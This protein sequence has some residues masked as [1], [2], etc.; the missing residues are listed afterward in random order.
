MAYLYNVILFQ[1]LLN[2][3]VGL[4]D[5]I[6]GHDIGLAIIFLTLLIRLAL[7][8]LSQRGL[9]S[10]RAMQKLQPKLK[11]LQKKYKKNR[12]VLAR[13]TMRLYKEHNIHP[14]SALLPALIQLP[15]LIALYQVFW[16]GF[17]EQHIGS[18]LSSTL[19]PFVGN[20][21]TLNP[22]MFGGFNLAKASIALA[23]AAGIAQFAQGKLMFYFRGVPQANNN[24]NKGN[25]PDMGRVMQTQMT[26]ILPFFTVF[27]ALRFPAALAL[28][29]LTT[30]L[31]T[32]GQEIYLARTNP[33]TRP[34][35]ASPE[36]KPR[37]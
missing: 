4:Y 23:I 26:Y 10:Q 1:P 2:A 35:A 20:P 33:S 14:F 22:I 6:P 24:N 3:L 21:G 28:Y 15:V 8:P 12:E 29:W 25:S 9:R 18:L 19:Y 7:F 17:D 13:Q 11:E 34:A 36:Q 30:T 27:I 31:F 32:V 37:E 16:A 5:I